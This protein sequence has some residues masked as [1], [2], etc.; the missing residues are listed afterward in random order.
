MGGIG[1]A[2]P[3]ERG[4]DRQV[5]RIHFQ[6]DRG[7]QRRDTMDCCRPQAGSR[8]AAQTRGP[9]CQERAGAHASAAPE[10]GPARPIRCSHAGHV[11][12]RCMGPL[13]GTGPAA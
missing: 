10:E 6:E 3:E 9:D 5:A 12:R 11:M 8:C 4:E 13:Q 2:R 7:W 1:P